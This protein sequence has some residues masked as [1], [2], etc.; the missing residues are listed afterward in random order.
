MDRG[1]TRAATLTKDSR[2]GKP[3][4]GPG[5]CD[6]FQHADRHSV[7]A[8]HA[9]PGTKSLESLLNQPARTRVNIAAPL[10]ERVRSVTERIRTRSAGLRTEYLERTRDT[11]CAQA[12]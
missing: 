8:G 10:H 6:A 1:Q 3:G 2:P 4:E 7:S 12:S 5:C 11:R 9:T